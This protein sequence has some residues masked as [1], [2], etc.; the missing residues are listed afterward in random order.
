MP[1]RVCRWSGTRSADKQLLHVHEQVTLE[2]VFAFLVFLRRLVCAVLYQPNE[3][4]L[5]RIMKTERS[6][7]VFPSQSLPAFDT[8]NVPNGMVSGGHL[9]VDGLALYNID[10]ERYISCALQCS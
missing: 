1:C 3:L 10:T 7:Y 2:D 8:V 5:Q 9:T 4:W 6:A